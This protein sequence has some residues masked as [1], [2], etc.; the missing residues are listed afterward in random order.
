MLIYPYNKGKEM[1]K[2]DYVKSTPK[3]W[4][5]EEVE[6]AYNKKTGRIYV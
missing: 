5:E 3:K 6:W 1:K 4:S 2:G